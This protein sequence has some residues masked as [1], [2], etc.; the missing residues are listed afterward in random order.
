MRRDVRIPQIAVLSCGDGARL[1][2][3]QY[4]VPDQRRDG[5]RNCDI[6]GHHV[7]FQTDDLQAAMRWAE[8]AGGIIMDQRMAD[9]GGGQRRRDLTLRARAQGRPV[10]VRHL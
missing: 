10:R 5:P 2:I 7:A 1:E 3:F 4:D 8:A 6:G 9:D